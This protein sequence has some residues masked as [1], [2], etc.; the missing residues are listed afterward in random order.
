MWRHDYSLLITLTVAGYSF[1]EGVK[2]FFWV[3]HL[4][5]ASSNWNA[6]HRGSIVCHPRI[7]LGL[8]PFSNGKGAVMPP[9]EPDWGEE[10]LFT[11]LLDSL[12]CLASCPNI[13]RGLFIFCQSRE[14]SWLC[15]N[16]NKAFLCAENQIFFFCGHMIFSLLN[17]SRE[18]HRAW[19]QPRDTTLSL[20][21]QITMF[22]RLWDGKKLVLFYKKLVVTVL[23]TPSLNHTH[24]NDSIC[25]PEDHWNLS[26]F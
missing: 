13:L 2:R 8:P 26:V 21:L 9:A 14:P 10:P 25:D 22:L 16:R 6:G 17:L 24:M 20:M 19:E 15:S 4:T 23:L 12:R 7:L 11:L 1:L 5:L 3:P 18:A